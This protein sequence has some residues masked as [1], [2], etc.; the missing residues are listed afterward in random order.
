MVCGAEFGVVLMAKGPYTSS[1]QQGL[2]CLDLDHS[3]LKGDLYFRLIV[4]LT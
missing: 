4:E 3:A 2:D 1:T